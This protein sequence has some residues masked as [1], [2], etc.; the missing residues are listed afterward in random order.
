[1]KKMYM[2]CILGIFIMLILFFAGCELNRI[3]PARGELYHLAIGLNYHGTNVAYLSGTINDARETALALESA[4]TLSHKR[5]HGMT[6]LQTGGKIREELSYRPLYD[7][8]EITNPILPTKINILNTLQ[9]LCKTMKEEDLLLCSFSGH[10]YN[11]G[12]LVVAPLNQ[13]GYIFKEDGTLDTQCLLDVETLLGTLKEFPGRKLL[14]LDSCY[15]GSFVKGNGSSVSLIENP[16]YIHEAFRQYISKEYAIPSLFVLAAT[17]ADNTSKEPRES[18]HPHGYFTEALL[19]GLGWNPEKEVPEKFLPP[20]CKKK[21]VTTDSLYA[22]IHDHQKIP[23]E[24]K[25]KY[26][27]QHPQVTGGCRDLILFTY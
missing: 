23:T 24:G 5:Y 13:K 3:P 8:D 27:Y 14:I 22:Y 6:M 12:S 25:I 9:N 21:A 15:C 16:S 20:A 26:L 10:G 18:S 11:D 4:C 19:K 7:Y 2:N 1:M 17:T